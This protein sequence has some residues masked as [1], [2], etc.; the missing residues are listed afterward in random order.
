MV[1]LRL[2]LVP[3][4]VRVLFPVFPLE[5]VVTVIVEVPEPVTEFGLKLDEARDGNPLTLRLT[6]P[7]KLFTAP[8]VTVYDVLDPRVIVWDEGVAE[9]V[10]SG[11]G[12]FIFS[13]TVVEWT[14][15]SPV[16]VIVSV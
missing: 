6:A 3:L 1:W 13:I 12:P 15:D 11:T 8:I 16:P 2:P 5:F 10:K 4:I 7:V 14:N 9:I